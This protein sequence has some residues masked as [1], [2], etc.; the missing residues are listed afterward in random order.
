MT[1]PIVQRIFERAAAGD[2]SRKIAFDLNDDGIIP[3]LKYRVL[4]IQ[5]Q[6]G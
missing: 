1:A 2:S 4:V 3:P 5:Q 6:M